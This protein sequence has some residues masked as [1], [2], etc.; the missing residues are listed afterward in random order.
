LYIQMRY[1]WDEQKNR[2][3]QK[4]HRISFEMAA[5]VFEDDC[6]LVRPDRVDETGEQ[7]WHAIGAA[8]LGSDAAV[9]LLV[10]HAYREEIDGEEITRIISARR[11]NKDDFQRYQ[12]QE[13]D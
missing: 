1:E 10:V 12:E 3:N 6:C 13:M 8:R 2:L 9:V 11:A 7:R 5:L 4:K